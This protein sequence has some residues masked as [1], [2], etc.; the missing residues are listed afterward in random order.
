MFKNAPFRSISGPPPAVPG[1]LGEP[2]TRLVLE[3]AEPDS[4]VGDL[5]NA[6][7]LAVQPFHASP[8][9]LL[10]AGNGRFG[11]SSQPA[12]GPAEG[13]LRALEKGG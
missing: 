11:P 13:P 8:D 1:L 7:V 12:V 5:G 4:V 9:S 10:Q 2:A 6:P 3:A